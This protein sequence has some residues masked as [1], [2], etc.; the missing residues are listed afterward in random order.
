M[1][2]RF[3]KFRIL[4]K[5]NKQTNEVT[6]VCH[7][8]SMPENRSAVDYNRYRYKHGKNRLRHP[9]Q[10]K[11]MTLCA[12]E[13]D[14]EF[15]GGMEKKHMAAPFF[16]QES[17]NWCKQSL[18]SRD[19]VTRARQWHNTTCLDSESGSVMPCS[20]SAFVHQFLDK[21]PQLTELW[22]LSP[23]RS[24]KRVC[25]H[26]KIGLWMAQRYKLKV[27]KP[28]F[29]LQSRV[30]AFTPRRGFLPF[31]K[32]KEPKVHYVFLSLMRECWTF[33]VMQRCAL[34]LPVK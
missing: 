20:S 15:S 28:W 18:Q 13:T 7:Q 11:M 29:W 23:S 32:W 9:V 6:N 5:V 4:Q 30:K 16:L 2:A 26:K 1:A 21:L 27:F 3:L 22:V 25:T 12:S 14:S 17:W 19:V 8:R 34:V 24:W 31:L 33:S 10:W